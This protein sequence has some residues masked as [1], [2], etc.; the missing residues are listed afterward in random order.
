M[1]KSDIGIYGLGVM[2]RNLALN[3]NDHDFQASVF[4]RLLPGE[5]TVVRDFLSG[6]AEGTNIQGYDNLGAFVQSLEKPKK[7]L[8]MVKAGAPVDAVIEQLLPFLDPADI[9]IDGGNSHYT[10]TNCRVKM[11]NDK[12]IHYIGMGISGGE[13]GAR[14]GPSL[15]PGG[16]EQ[17][18]EELKPILQ[19][20]AATTSDGTACCSWMGAE[21][22]G[23]FVKM[24]HNGIEYAVMQLIS[25]CYHLMKSPLNMS[26]SQIKEIFDSWNTGLLKSYLL[27][28]TADILD[29]KDDNQRAIIDYILDTAGQKGT[30]RWTAIT[31]LEL[32]IPAPLISEAVFARSLSSFKDLRIQASQNFDINSPIDAPDEITEHLRQTLLGG[33]L[34][35][36][37]EGFW[38]LKAANNEFDWNISFADVANV[39]RG[40]CIIRSALLEP[41]ADAYQEN[42]DLSH[43]LLA[44]AF[45]KKLQQVQ[46]GWRP[47]TKF[48]LECGI[49][50]PA[51]T[52]ALSH[53]DALRTEKLP[54]NLIQAQ[55]DYFGAHQYER[56]DRPR[57]EFF[58]T[59]W[60]KRKDT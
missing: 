42:P 52:S 35:A 3:I 40:G 1:E 58:H 53:F 39:W 6:K 48:G 33:T 25:E 49:P 60:K 44:P 57:G 2:G 22:A 46:E 13:E 31:A 34:V 14:N 28:I 59:N 17:V 38:L 7:I 30:G 45:E 37:A 36:F 21:G 4:N 51:M 50:L 8:L 32:G 26:N 5:E 29:T 23:H 10:D 11:L 15:M 18:W 24:V 20:I 41:I 12:N 16:N 47:A 43:L 54:A 27:E 56:T 19:S 55:R 9:L